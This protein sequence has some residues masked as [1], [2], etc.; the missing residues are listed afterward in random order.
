[1]E[2]KPKFNKLLEL[3]EDKINLMW[4][5]QTTNSYFN[6]HLQQSKIDKYPDL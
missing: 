6:E 5:Q 1:M 2:P 3:N 4:I